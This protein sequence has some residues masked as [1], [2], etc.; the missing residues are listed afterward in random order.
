M[1]D[2]QTHGVL[3]QMI[4]IVLD[5]LDKEKL[6]LR[7]DS[8]LAQELQSIQEQ[9]RQD[10]V[11]T[12][13]CDSTYV[14]LQSVISQVHSLN[15]TL[16]AH[17]PTV[18]SVSP[19]VLT[20]SLLEHAYKL[21]YLTDPHNEER[22]QRT[23]KLLY[24][25]IKQYLILPKDLTSP[26]GRELA[27]NQAKLAE[28]WYC[29]LTGGKE[30]MRSVTAMEIFKAVG[31]ETNEEKG[32]SCK[33]TRVPMQGKRKSVDVSLRQFTGFCTPAPSELPEHFEVEQC[34][35]ALRTL[36]RERCLGCSNS[37]QDPDMAAVMPDSTAVRAHMC[38]AGG[39]KKGGASA[40]RA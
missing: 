22:L 21:A 26:A 20:R 12:Y 29:D 14:L 32:N 30:K 1:S 5:Y 3:P 7:E 10:L 23:L 6:E 28:R 39:S 36:G 40:N 33:V 17:S 15:A 19:Y 25:D 27:E 18:F 34:F 37:A 38:A 31:E 4:S 24:S 9:E 2:H 35:Q 16:N 8:F 13:L 11:R